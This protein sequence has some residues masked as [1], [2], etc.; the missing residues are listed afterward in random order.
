MKKS[1][2]IALASF[3]LL[4]IPALAADGAGE[5]LKI[6]TASDWKAQIESSEGAVF[7]NGSAAPEGK[8]ATIRTKLH[9]FEKKVAAESLTIEQSAIWQN[10]EPIENLGPSNLRDAPVMLTMG[11][12]DY[13]MFGR[14]GGGQPKVKKG[15]KRKP[16]PKF[17][18]KPATLEG[19]DIPLMTTRFPNQFDAPGGLKKGLGGYHAWQSRDMKNWVHHGAV[20]DKVSCW[21]TTAEQKDGKVYIYYD[22][23]NDQDPHL[24]IDSDL[25]DGVPGENKGMAF[26]DPTHGSDC[27]FIRD[28]EGRFHVIYEDWSHID[29][30]KRSWDSP[31]AGHAVSEDGIGDFEILK[32]AIDVRTKPTGEKKTYKHPHWL[33]HPDWDTN[34]GEY[35]VHSPEQGAHGDWAS[36][37]VGGQYYLFGDYDPPG[38]HQMSVGWFTSSSLD[39]QFTWCDNIGKG[40]PDPDIAFAEDRFYLATQQKVDYVSSGPWVEKVSARVGVDTDNDSK[41]DKWTDWDELK[42]SYDY[43]PGRSKQV[44]KTPARLDLSALPDGFGF[45]IEL[46]IEDTTENKSKP[47]LEALTLKVGEPAK[48]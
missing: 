24:Y 36:I 17:E 1:T 3:H 40:H 29:A 43:T 44:A 2:T 11:K 13:W 42:E 8:T 31:V 6:D 46:K 41:I 25:T 37:C 15:E 18:A 22:Y 9:K 30:S 47:I 20:T 10:W 26:A 12:D 38:G 5:E 28:A 19:F 33:Q 7:E 21:V 23:P 35:E 16:L 14:Y 45:Q 39:E 32:P 34:L 48:K 27:G 4:A